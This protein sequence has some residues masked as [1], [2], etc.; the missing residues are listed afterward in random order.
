MQYLAFITVV[1]VM[2]YIMHRQQRTIDTLTDKLMA[3]D[4]G[5]YKRN[6][7]ITISDEKPQRK[8]LSYYD[9]PSIEVE[10]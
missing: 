7:H 10:N 8:P 5:E 2:G 6:N 3:K 9:D 4:Y 1:A